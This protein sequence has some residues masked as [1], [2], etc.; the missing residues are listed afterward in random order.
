MKRRQAHKLCSKKRWPPRVRDE[1]F[2][3]AMAVCYRD[4]RKWC[5]MMVSR[6]S[7]SKLEGEV[8]K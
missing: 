4:L 5:Q 1:T 8:R 6:C 2:R 7:E 3:R